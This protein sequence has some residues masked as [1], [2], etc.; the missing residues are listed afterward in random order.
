[1]ARA[2]YI[3]IIGFI[4]IS[5]LGG[6]TLWKISEDKM[7]D[8]IIT[9]AITGN[10]IQSGDL[11]GL[12]ISVFVP[13]KYQYVQAG[14]MLQFQTSIKNI[15][16]SGRHDIQL[17]YY[18]KKNDIVITHRREL[19]AVETQSSFLSSIKV[20]EETL[21]GIYE[22]NVAINEE[23]SAIATFYVKSSDVGQIKTYLIILIIA[24]LVVGILIFWELHRLVSKIKKR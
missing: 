11:E 14:E 1:M 17:D 19:K 6:V 2:I 12:E 5:L 18:I 13:E 3:L 4:V 15:A 23:E 22:I 16:R 24:I 7:G 9:G 8:G 10:V 20:P 21:P